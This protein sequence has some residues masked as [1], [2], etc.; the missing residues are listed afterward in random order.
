M[1]G[2]LDLPSFPIIHNWL[3]KKFRIRFS[4]LFKTYNVL[5][6]ASQDLRTEHITVFSDFSDGMLSFFEAVVIVHPVISSTD[7][8]EDR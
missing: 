6:S 8:Q 3:H 4:L 2:A 7:C 5:L 1:N